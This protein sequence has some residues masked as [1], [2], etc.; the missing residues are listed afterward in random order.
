MIGNYAWI[1][2]RDNV[3]EPGDGLPSRKGWAGP[4]TATKDQ[5]A[6]ARQGRPFRMFC[7]GEPKP[8]YY[9]QIWTKEEPGSE[10]D[11]GP[12]D[13]LGRPDAGCVAIQYRNSEGE[14]EML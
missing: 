4:G 8:C 9:G 10:M 14:W 2:T 5:V 1:I 13:D 6:K 7:D 12:L 11:F 3:T